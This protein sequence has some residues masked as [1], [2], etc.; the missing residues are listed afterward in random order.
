MDG[1]VPE[2][3]ELTE[4]VGS[5][6]R[7]MTPKEQKEALKWAGEAPSLPFYSFV[8]SSSKGRIL[9][10]ITVTYYPLSLIIARFTGYLPF[11]THYVKY[12]INISSL[13]HQK[14]P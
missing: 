1:R 9:K 7:E 5:G 12:F 2:L 3:R 4:F 11:S 8:F 6:C 10:F 14:I 13:N